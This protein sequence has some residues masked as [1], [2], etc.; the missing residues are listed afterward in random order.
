MNNNRF[1]YLR[2]VSPTIEKKGSDSVLIDEGKEATISCKVTKSNPLPTFSWQYTKTFPDKEVQ[3]ITVPSR[4]ILTNSS[5]PSSESIVKVEK[6][7][8]PT[9]YRCQA[10]NSL[11]ND[12]YNLSFDRRGK[13]IP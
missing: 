5:T 9:T 10:R 13:I 8:P 4:L 11:G 7:Q 6:N 3:W 1:Y 2:T 12:S